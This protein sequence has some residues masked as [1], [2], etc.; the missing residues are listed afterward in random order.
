MNKYDKNNGLAALEN[1]QVGRLA[2]IDNST[3]LVDGVD[4]DISDVYVRWTGCRPDDLLGNIVPS[5]Y[6]RP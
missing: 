1:L 6:M 4:K 5:D 3:G 2:V